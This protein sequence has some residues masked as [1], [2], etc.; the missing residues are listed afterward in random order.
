MTRQAFDLAKKEQGIISHITSLQP[1]NPL[2][3]ADE[4]E[5]KA[6]QAFEK[7][8]K[9]VSSLEI[10]EGKEYMRLMKRLVI[11]ESCLKCHAFYGSKIGDIRGGISEAIP[12]APL[13]R[14]A[15]HRILHLSVI[16]IIFW[17]LGLIGL[18]I[19]GKV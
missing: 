19:T 17:T 3:E 1:I 2:N 18:V 14:I 9:E 11:D 7:G 4:W 5:K 16:H 8:T 15:G 10:I 6:L 13:N 12:M